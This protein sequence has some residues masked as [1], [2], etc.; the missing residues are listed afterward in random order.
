MFEYYRNDL[1]I[2]RKYKHIC[3]KEVRV[4]YTVNTSCRKPTIHC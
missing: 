4:S 1:D 2:Q 3:D